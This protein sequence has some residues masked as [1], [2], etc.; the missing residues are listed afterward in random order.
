[1][2]WILAVGLDSEQK[3]LNSTLLTRVNR[4]QTTPVPA[5]FDEQSAVSSAL[6]GAAEPKVQPTSSGKQQAS[7]TPILAATPEHLEHAVDS[8]GLRLVNPS[9]TQSLEDVPL[10]AAKFEIFV[11]SEDDKRLSGMHNV[12]MALLAVAFIAFLVFASRQTQT[13]QR[14][15]HNR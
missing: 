7:P 2:Q 6:A 15:Q 3:A 9:S 1:M 10:Y 13:S 5:D 14:R 12:A 11:D 4:P 8:S